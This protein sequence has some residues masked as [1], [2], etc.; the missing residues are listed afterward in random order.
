MRKF[1]LVTMTV[2]ALAALG[3]TLAAQGHASGKGPN[4]GPHTGAHA[5]GGGQSAN[6]PSSTK[7]DAN[8]GGAATKTSEH[9]SERGSEKKSTRPSASKDKSNGSDERTTSTSKGGNAT[10]QSAS[11]PKAISTRISKNPHQLSRITAMLPAGMTLEEAS[12]GFRNQGQFIA[13]LNASKNQQIDFVQLK[14]AMT[15]DG[16]SLGQAAKQLRPESARSSTPEQTG[17]TT[18]SG[19][20]GSSTSTGLAAQ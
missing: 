9:G 3:T 2:V 17:E 8:G 11:E 4:K 7:G 18:R 1:S 13:A 15:V 20:S 12:A 6:R 10:A 14:E 5:K 19:S 16:L